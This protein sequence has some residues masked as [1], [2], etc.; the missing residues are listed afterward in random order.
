MRP[1]GVLAGLYMRE[2]NFLNYVEIANLAIPCRVGGGEVPAM[3]C[4]PLPLCC[5]FTIWKKKRHLEQ[6]AWATFPERRS[7]SQHSE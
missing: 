2:L 5:Y 4:W 1:F 3:Y 7:C 6:R